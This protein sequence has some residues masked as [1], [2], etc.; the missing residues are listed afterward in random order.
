MIALADDD[1]YASGY[2][3]EQISESHV[4]TDAAGNSLTDLIFNN[5]VVGIKYYCANNNQTYERFI[6]PKE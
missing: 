4:F 3:G 6:K 2:E 1:D 5:E